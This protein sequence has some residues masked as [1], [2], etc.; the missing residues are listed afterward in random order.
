MI[1]NL[2]SYKISYVVNFKCLIKIF[3]WE[4]QF[5]LRYS[6]KAVLMKKRLVLILFL[7]CHYTEMMEKKIFNGHTKQLNTSLYNFFFFINLSISYIHFECYSLSRFPGKHPP[8]PSPSSWVFPSQPSPHCRPP[9]HRLVHCG[10][11]L[12]RTQGFPFHWCSY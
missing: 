10:F 11:S 1:V 12:S 4:I 6:G 3:A 9:P 8:P 5:P 7:T 2:Y